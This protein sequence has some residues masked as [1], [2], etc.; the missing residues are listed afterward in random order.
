VILRKHA[1]MLVDGSVTIALEVMIM[2]NQGI[3]SRRFMMKRRLR[4]ETS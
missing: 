4:R 1:R 3:I 2:K